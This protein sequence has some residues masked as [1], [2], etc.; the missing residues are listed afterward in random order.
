MEMSGQGN[1][2]VTFGAGR[3]GWIG[4]AKRITC[5]AE[6]SGLFDFCFNLDENWLKAWDPDIYDNGLRLRKSLPPRGFG[7]WTWKPSVLLWADLYFP[8]HQIVYIDAG[9][10]FAKG[11]LVGSELYADLVNSYTNKGL[12]WTLLGHSERAWTKVDLLQHLDLP[13]EIINSDQ[14][15]SGFIALSPLWDRRSFLEKWRELA[16]VQSGFLFT[17]ISKKE[18]SEIYVEHRHDQ[19]VFSC[20]WKLSNLPIITDKTNP[21]KVNGYQL[22]AW[23]NNSHLRIETFSII[24]KFLKLYM[25][26]KD[27]FLRIR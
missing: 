12:A 4:A 24:R 21:S 11:N 19:S 25:L 17:D 3:S 7:Y 2:F 9:S 18:N 26:T 27:F 23:R 20:L 15:Q 16:L 8:T 14:V 13:P 6:K 22:L 1:I 10:Q 5:E